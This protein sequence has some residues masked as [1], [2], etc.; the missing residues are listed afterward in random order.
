MPLKINILKFTINLKHIIA[1][2][3]A[4]FVAQGLVAQEIIE[5][6]EE[7]KKQDSVKPFTEQK[8]DG[9]AA[10]VG[11][12][13]VLDSDV[14]LEY[15]KLKLRG[16]NLE[17]FT[18]CQL[19]GKLLEDKL[20]AH[21]AIQDSIVVNEAEIRSYVNQQIDEFKLRLNGSLDEVLKLYKKEDEKSLREEMIEINRTQKLVSEMQKKIVD[22]IEVTPEEVRIFFNKIPKDQRPV[23]GTELKVSQIVI[24]PKVTLEAKQEVIDQLKGFK[25]DI[26]ENG[27][28]FRSKAVLYSDDKGSK[29]TGGFYTLNKSRPRMV[30]EFRE[31]AFSLQEGEISDPFKTEFGYHI[32]YLEK[33]RGQEYDVR[34]ILRVP[35]VSSKSIKEAKDKIESI[36]KNILDGNITF[37]D[38]AKESSDEVKTKYQGGKLINP[39][40]QDYNFELTKMDP[41]LYGQIQNLK[42]GEISNVI[43]DLDRSENVKFKILSIADRID[44]H[45]ADYSRDYLKIKELALNEKRIKAI[46]KWQDETIEATYIKVSGEYRNC[47]FNSNWL[48]K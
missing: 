32:I 27:A 20:Y 19:F 29:R 9:V 48:K 33:I 11:D 5:E 36:R 38:A 35:D 25:R 13:I 41:E 1:L 44:E 3:L 21:Q 6:K 45:E 28:N 2:S 30:K 16:A 18:E 43:E 14:A 15:E 46:D 40:T 7:V 37:E 24:E 39:T 34:H 22:E 12:F 8:V 17:N 47:D 26:E 42:D 10:V 23:F 4:L 31:V